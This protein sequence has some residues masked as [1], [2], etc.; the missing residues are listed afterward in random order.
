LAETTVIFNVPRGTAYITAQ[1]LVIYA[2]SF[3][4][5]VL[6]IRILNLS[7]IGEVSLLAAASA[8][9]TTITQLALPLAATRFISASI[10]GKDPSTAGAVQRTSLR[11]VITIAAPTLLLS[12]LASP[13]IASTVFKN[14]DATS[15]LVVAFVASFLLDLTAL[16]GAY[17]LGLG[18]YANMAY[19]NI[20]F[21]PLSRGLGLVLAYKSLGPLGIPAGWAIGASAALALSIFL[22]KGKLPKSENFSA[23]TLLVFSF[24][25]FASAL[26]TL[27]QGWGDIAL[28]Q[29]IL[30][31]F[32][33]TGAYY[34]VVTSVSFLSILW[35][36]A[37]GALYPALSSGYTSQGPTGVSE[38]LGVAMRLVN[39]TVLPTGTALAVIAP[40]ALE[41]VYGPSLLAGAIP[42]AILAITIIFSAQSLLLITTLQAIGKTK[43]I[44]GISLAATILDLAAVALGARPLGTTAGAIGRALLALGM[45][46]L[47]WWTLRRV[48]HVPLTHGLSKALL[49]AILT[50]TPTAIADYALATSI[51][52]TPLFRLPVLVIVFDL[53]FL[54][55]SRELSV[56][57][58]T[59]FDLLENALPKVLGS[60]LD[61]AEHLLLRRRM[62]PRR[63]ML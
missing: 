15:F 51:H 7:Q 12:V 50:A 22:M 27:L 42:F 16:Y 14:P 24:P 19:Q 55:V 8:G 61:T 52:F 45:M 11:L 57:T 53:S 25:L 26:V 37:A 54:I 36:P 47:A 29:A 18:R 46:T 56:F 5:Y 6:L 48:L 23:R 38:K 62:D 39:L 21:H 13:W 49:V 28:L 59:D 17:F 58:E 33:T 43:P 40:T 44:L 31:Q 9:F 63:N 1:Q 4:Y 35:A 10:G 41:A 60:A 2:S 30:G 20:L 34:L 32:G 3:V